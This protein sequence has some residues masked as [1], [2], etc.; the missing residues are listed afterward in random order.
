MT[1][2]VHAY[3]S[4]NNIIRVFELNTSMV[5]GYTIVHLVI[6]ILNW[7][8]AWEIFGCDFYLVFRTV[9]FHWK[10]AASV[11]RCLVEIIGYKT[12][13][14]SICIYRWNDK[15]QR[16]ATWDYSTEMRA[17]KHT[18]IHTGATATVGTPVISARH[19]IMKIHVHHL[20]PLPAGASIQTALNYDSF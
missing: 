3:H 17:R 9:F 14:A 4:E 5:I 1:T 18:H 2:F 19:K 7:C 8:N 15:F 16:T 20:L 11:N 12:H 6:S 10:F 13:G